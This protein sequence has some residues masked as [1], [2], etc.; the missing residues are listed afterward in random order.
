MSVVCWPPVLVNVKWGKEKYDVELDSD[1]PP[2]LLKNVLYSLSGVSPER[3]KLMIK[4]Q[5][6]KVGVKRES[7]ETNRCI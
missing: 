2:L 6:V 4:G 5:T 7:S 1:E 3:M